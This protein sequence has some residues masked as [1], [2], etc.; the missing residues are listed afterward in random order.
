MS[1]RQQDRPW[2]PGV[3]GKGRVPIAPFPKWPSSEVCPPAK[4]PSRHWWGLREE[5]DPLPP[6]GDLNPGAGAWGRGWGRS[7]DMQGS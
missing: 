6:R 2:G 1:Q 7:S 4:S 3:T 5:T